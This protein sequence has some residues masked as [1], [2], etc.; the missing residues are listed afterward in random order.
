MASHD[1]SKRLIHEYHQID[2]R[3]AHEF[4]DTNIAW[5]VSQNVLDKL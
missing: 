3:L 1:V 4:S 2:L 5:D